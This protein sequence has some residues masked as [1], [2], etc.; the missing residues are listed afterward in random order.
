MTALIEKVDRPPHIQHQMIVRQSTRMGPRVKRNPDGKMC[1]VLS[2]YVQSHPLWLIVITYKPRS[3]FRARVWLREQSGKNR[4][5]LDSDGYYTLIGAEWAAFIALEKYARQ[6]REAKEQ[7]D[8][9]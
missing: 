2:S 4:P 1:M 6:L 3:S 7:A 5:L 9:V 8:V